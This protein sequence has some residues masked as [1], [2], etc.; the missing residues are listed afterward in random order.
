M[1]SSKTIFHRC[2]EFFAGEKIFH[3]RAYFLGFCSPTPLAAEDEDA[4]GETIPSLDMVFLLIGTQK[5]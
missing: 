3:K 5:T 1:E 4:V 2:I